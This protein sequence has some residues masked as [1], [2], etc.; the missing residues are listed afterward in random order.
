MDL[1]YLF[2]E[3][4]DFGTESDCTKQHKAGRFT[5]EY[6][7]KNYYNIE[8]PELEI[9][10]KKPKFKYSDIQFSI[11]HC[12]NI[13]CVCFD[14]NPVGF[15]IE[16]IKPRDFEAIAKR[17][18]FKLKENSL[19]EFY[20]NWTMYEAEIKLQAA[21]K[22]RYCASFLD[23]YIMSVVSAKSD[24]IEINFIEITNSK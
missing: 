20:K 18:N 15:D 16:E 14:N 7:A 23:K 8:N 22:S 5:V 1:F 19:E 2:T 17:M 24:N 10:N 21:A 12:R 11:S 6:A 13:V 4:F 3:N 9:I